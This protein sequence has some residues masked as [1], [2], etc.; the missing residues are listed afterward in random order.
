MGCGSS[1]QAHAVN[2]PGHSKAQGVVENA[3][4]TPSYETPMDTPMDITD[5]ERSKQSTPLAC[6]QEDLGATSPAARDVP[7][8]I[9]SLSPVDQRVEPL[10]APLDVDSMQLPVH[11]ETV[12]Y[13]ERLAPL[14]S[15]SERP[16]TSSRRPQS[17][18]GKL[19][20]YQTEKQKQLK[21]EAKKK[22]EAELSSSP[23]NPLSLPPITGHA[24]KSA[25]PPLKER[26]HKSKMNVDG[27]AVS[28]TLVLAPMKPVRD[29]KGSSG[30]EAWEVA[31]SEVTAEPSPEVLKFD[32][33]LKASDM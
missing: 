30:G 6:H 16:G 11:E 5:E 33:P 26:K 24:K 7:Q 10:H 14:P 4:K 25:L 27:D 1:T 22:R 3:K 21:A 28:D 32:S 17:A 18:S 12:P 15:T 9:E 31:V 2:A 13:W 23:A 20:V 19:V 29:W 8:S